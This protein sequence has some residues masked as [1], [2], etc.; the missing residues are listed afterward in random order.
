MPGPKQKLPRTSSVSPRR[1]LIRETGSVEAPERIAHPGR[2]EVV[3]AG[4]YHAVADASCRQFSELPVVERAAL[5]HPVRLDVHAPGEWRGVQ[6]LLQIT[7]SW[8]PRRRS[9]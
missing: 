9:L 3:I 1:P 8:R 4:G 5:G 6:M 2:R 7:H